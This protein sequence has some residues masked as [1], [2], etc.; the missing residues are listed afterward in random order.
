MT[1]PPAETMPAF[2]PY[3]TIWAKVPSSPF[4]SFRP[5]NGPVEHQTDAPPTSLADGRSA[6]RFQVSH[7]NA[8]EVA[9]RQIHSVAICSF[10]ESVRDTS[11]SCKLRK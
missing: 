1:N 8:R 6:E 7:Q 9:A 10:F 4:A 11:R 3:I 2:Q 5:R